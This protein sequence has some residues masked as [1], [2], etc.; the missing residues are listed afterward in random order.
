ML[1]KFFIDR[2]VFAVVISLVI[3]FAGLAA[4]NTLPTAQYPEIAPPTV[5]VSCM[6]TG[7]NAVVV[8]ET[9][10]APIEQEINGV[11]DML[12]MSSQ[13]TND[14]GYRL[15][16]TFKLGTDLDMAQV[17]VQNRVS[18]ALSKLPDIVKATVTTK[19]KSPSIL[20]VVNM[21]SDSDSNGKPIHSQLD[22][23]N[24]ATI[25]V[26]DELLRLNGVGDVGFLGQ[27]DYSMRVWLNPERLA[28]R[29]MT[30]SDVLNALKEQNVQVAAGRIGQPPTPSGIDFQYTLSTLGR[31]VEPEQFGQIIVKT[32][33]AGEIT[34]LRDVGELELGAKNQDT[35]CT[36]DGNPSV[37][38][39]IYQLP[40]SNA[41]ATA[42]LIRATMR[43]LEV[44]FKPGMHYEIAYDTT[45]F[46]KQ[47]VDEVFMPCA[48]Q[49]FSSQ[50]SF[51][52][53]C[54][55]GSR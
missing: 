49:S 47:S 30:T 14:G 18:Q 51:C 9:V 26:R 8:Q 33:N 21:Y 6:Y 55:T 15:N 32:G 37:G 3:V 20:L 54:R 40:G 38:L 50:S 43:R 28:A 25:F 12:Y 31:L 48:M 39:A 23:S 13:S 22:L 52:C 17:K 5:E 44:R 27:M 35:Q 46:I 7:A 4:L 11:E 29:N 2:P 53:S 42:D 24:Y 1:A 16:V 10:A 19:K 45:P 34:R 36:L 41:L